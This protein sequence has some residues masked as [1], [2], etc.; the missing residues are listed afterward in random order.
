[1]L[2]LSRLIDEHKCYDT[3]RQR[4]WPDGVCCLECGSAAV[5]KRGKHVTHPARQRYVCSDCG[6]QFDDLT[7]TIF[8]GRH[9][10]LSAWIACLYLMGL[11]LANQQIA[12]ELSLHKDD[13]HQMTSELRQAV[14]DKRPEVQL[15]GVVEF[16]EVYVTAG[17]KGHP[18]AVKKKA[19]KDGGAS[20]KGFGDAVRSKRRS[21]RSSA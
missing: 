6:R 1:M 20:S 5:T 10:P 21:P 9:Q 13:V 17:H 12:Q 14:S 11:N 19:V 3:V 16:D 2:T 18:E 7:G 4:R 15:S 8:A